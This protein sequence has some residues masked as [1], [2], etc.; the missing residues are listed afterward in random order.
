MSNWFE[1]KIKYH[2]NDEYGKLKSVTEGYILDALSFSEAE[3]RI[4]HLLADIIHVEYNLSSVKFCRVDEIVPSELADARWYKAKVIYKDIDEQSG[5]EAKTANTIYVAG[6]G[7]KEALEALENSL[8]N[9]LV[10]WEIDTLTA[11]KIMDI[12]PWSDDEEPAA[13]KSE[14]GAAQPADLG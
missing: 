14:E 10:D 1:C 9:L 6:T 13:G 5:K 2:I 4:S 7:F 8:E 11:T 3:A 12:F